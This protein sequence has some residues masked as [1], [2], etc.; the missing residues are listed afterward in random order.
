MYKPTLSQRMAR[1]GRDLE[2]HHVPP[3]MFYSAVP[4]PAALSYSE[5]G[6][7]HK[8]P[9]LV[10]TP[11]PQQLSVSAQ[12]K[13]QPGFIAGVNQRSSANLVERCRFMPGADPASL[14]SEL[15]Q[16]EICCFS[17]IYSG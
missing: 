15:G 4:K 6:S 13:Q 1:V 10:A 12:Q 5:C 2:H 3:L 17:I 14:F 8:C 16:I 7:C 11:S 9:F